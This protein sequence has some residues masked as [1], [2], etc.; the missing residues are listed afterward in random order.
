M[1]FNPFNHCLLRL[2]DLAATE[3]ARHSFMREVLTTGEL[4]EDALTGQ[5]VSSDT[6]RICNTIA[7]ASDWSVVRIYPRFL[8]LIGPPSNVSS[9]RR[10]IQVYIRG[11]SYFCAGAFRGRR[12][13]AIG[14]TDPFG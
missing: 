4:A 3:A 8:R 9:L 1:D 12:Y 10:F 6:D 11:F 2:K 13:F 5:R 7:S 14:V